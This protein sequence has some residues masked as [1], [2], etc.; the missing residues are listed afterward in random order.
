MF[1]PGVVMQASVEE[2]ILED[3]VAEDAEAAHKNPREYLK[4]LRAL[5]KNEMSLAG[6]IC[7][8]KR[9]QII[10]RMICHV[11]KPLKVCRVFL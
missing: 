1:R 6:E 5:A 8:D 3:R 9:N 11:L 2:R 7:S 4:E 10:G